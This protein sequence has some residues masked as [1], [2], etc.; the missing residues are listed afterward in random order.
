MEAAAADGEGG[1]VDEGLLDELAA[2]S[3]AVR[4]E[5]AAA[6]VRLGLP[7]TLTLTPTLAQTLTLAFTLTL[8]LAFTLALTLLLT[9]TRCGGAY[10]TR[11]T[12]PTSYSVLRSS[13]RR[14]RR[15]RRQRRRPRRARRRWRPRP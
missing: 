14:E 12:R 6:S 11:Y 4:R 3:P 7:L 9:L 2:L 1:E 8:A 13:G 5:D 10:T 15:C